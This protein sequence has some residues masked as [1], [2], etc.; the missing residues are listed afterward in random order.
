MYPIDDQ[1]SRRMD[2]EVAKGHLGA[3]LAFTRLSFNY[4]ITETVFRYI[5][6]AVHLIADEGWKLLALYRFDPDSGLWQHR[7]GAA[8]PPP[9][10]RD[11]AAALDGAPARLATAP[12][13]VLAGQLEAAR[14]II[15]AVRARPPAGPAARPGAQRRLRARP[16]VPA[17]GGGARAA[18]DLRRID[19]LHGLGPSAAPPW[20][21]QSQAEWCRVG[22]NVQFRILGPVEATAPDG[23]VVA[24]RGQPLRLLGLLLVRRGE[25]VG[26]DSA[27]DALWGEGLPANPANALQVVVSRLRAAVGAEAIAWHGGGYALA[28]DDPEAV[29]ADRF[30]RLADEGAA[31][32]DRGERRRRGRRAPCGDGAVARAGAARAALRVV[33]RGG[34]GAPG[35]DAP[36]LPGSAPRGRPRPRAPR[37][38]ARRAHGARRRASAA[39]VAAPA[40]RAG[41][42]EQRAPGRG[43]RGRPRRRAARWPTTSASRPRPS[44][45][46]CSTASSASSALPARRQVVCV[47]ADVRCAES[48]GP[49]DPEVLEEVMRCCSDE[50]A[51]V[52]R[53][54]GDPVVERL[55]DGLVAVF[56]TRA[57]HEDDGLRA[58]RAATALQRR[59]GELAAGGACR[60]TSAS[61]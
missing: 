10:L 32:L 20:A 59:L 42:R 24:V 29:D 48:V 56:G 54:H 22:R 31:A 38:G 33:R 46:R 58:V 25:P 41:A 37:A 8:D 9:S 2:A 21:P 13:S 36:G 28:L 12:E 43:A 14:E 6:D 17:S 49:L 53:R 39:R 57:S 7:G 45:P 19:L 4:F 1:W 52:L 44:S 60:S 26:A 61:A 3:K 15:D 16:L 50:A 27:I 47:A 30:A 5:V 23:R 11:F 35:G 40:A 18:A 51:T 34:G 55:P